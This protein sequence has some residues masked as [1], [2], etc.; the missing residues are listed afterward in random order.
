MKRDHVITSGRWRALVAGIWC[1]SAFALAA[2]QAPA[3]PAGTQPSTSRP[4]RTA[5]WPRCAGAGPRRG[6]ERR[7]VG[8]HQPR[9]DSGHAVADSRR[10]AAAAAGRR[11]R[12]RSGCAARRRHRALRRQG[13]LEVD[14][15][16][17]GQV[18]DAQWLVHDGIFESGT[19]QRAC[20]RAR[21]SATS[22][23]TSSS[24]RPRRSKARARAAATAACASWTATRSR[25]S[26]RTTTGPTPTA[27]RRRSTGTRRRW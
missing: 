8:V 12:R 20:P 2:Q 13:P 11:S 15:S 6:P 14:A 17:Q 10:Q 7:G 24:P 23:C 3:P 26:T 18:T 21:A 9:R 25:C 4:R 16:R 1:C 5:G 22:S 19:G 27:W